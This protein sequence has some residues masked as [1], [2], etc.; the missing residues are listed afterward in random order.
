MGH[1]LRSQGLEAHWAALQ[2]LELGV[3][4]GG[5]PGSVCR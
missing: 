3:D 4:D 5:E 2:P 1:S